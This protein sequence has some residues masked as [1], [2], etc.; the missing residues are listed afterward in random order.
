MKTRSRFLKSSLPSQITMWRN[1]LAR[2]RSGSSA[3]VTRSQ[4][5]TP[6]LP[7]L[8]V[9]PAPWPTLSELLLKNSPEESPQPTDSGFFA[10]L[11]GGDP[12]VLYLEHLNAPGL[13]DKKTVTLVTELVGTRKR[14][15]QLT[16]EEK[17]LLNK[18]TLELVQYRPKKDKKPFLSPSERSQTLSLLDQESDGDDTIW[19]EEGTMRLAPKKGSVDIPDVSPYWWKKQ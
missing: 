8:P 17:D 3:S 18:A 7:P 16:P 14:V 15:H 13:L 12:R 5:L 4:G 19:D 6:P 1:T 9:M 10:T 11:V 2:Y